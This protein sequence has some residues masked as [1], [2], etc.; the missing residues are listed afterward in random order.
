V[1]RRRGEYLPLES[2]EEAT[3]YPYAPA[4][5]SLIARNR[6]R[7]FIGTKTTVLERLAAMIDATKADEVMVT[8]MIYDHGARRRSYELLAEAFGLDAGKK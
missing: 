3:A 4:E 1:R 2:P 6:A 5:R 8:T 7:L